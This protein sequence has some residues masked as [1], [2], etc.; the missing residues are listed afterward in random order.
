MNNYRLMTPQQN[1]QTMEQPR[2]RLAR[3]EDI[4]ELEVMIEQSM[5]ALGAQDYSPAQIE[6]ALKY[7]IGIDARL[8][9][10]KTFYVVTMQEQLVGCGGWSRY[11]QLHGSTGDSQEIPIDP[12]NDT[13][14]VRTM[15]VHPGFARL[16]IGSLIMN[17]CITEA[18]QAGFRHLEL[19][20]TLTGV[21]LYARFG[22]ITLERI[23][24]N[25]PDGV[26]VPVERMIK[27]L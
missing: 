5:R 18:R 23:E 16:G 3:L 12:A 13:A 22:F 27:A 14:K 6:S 26:V 17:K 9:K 24:F 8:I 1:R 15:F 4:P 20:A 19:M 11:Q 2:L 7:G 10:G 25:Q 21:N